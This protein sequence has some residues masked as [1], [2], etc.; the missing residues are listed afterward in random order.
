[1][2]M[3][4]NLTLIIFSLIFMSFSGKFVSSCIY[5][6]T[7][8]KAV[9]SFDGAKLQEEYEL[10]WTHNKNRVYFKKG[11]K[12]KVK[13]LDVDEDGSLI[14]TDVQKDKSGEYKGIVYDSEGSLIKETVQQLCVLE[15][16]SEP[17]VVVEC[18][19]KG[20]NLTCSAENHREVL[21]SWMRNHMEANVTH[22]FLHISLSEIKS[23]DSF[24]CTVSNQISQKSA[25]E[26]QPACSDADTSE[27]R[28]LFGLDSW[29][30]LV[31]LTGGGSFLI[32][33]IICLVAV[34]CCCG[35]NKRK[36]KREEQHQL[37]SLMPYL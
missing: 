15:P 7:G 5:K 27:K 1:M 33:F 19:E 9:I 18:V 4:L 31:I 11:S 22:A 28:F 23:G 24:S 26:V 2:K 20:V 16:V 34:C 21:V 25:K 17:T 36:A 13:E 3:L 12:V 29:L 10:K 6:A 30:M 32:L 35:R 14:L 8:E 37:V